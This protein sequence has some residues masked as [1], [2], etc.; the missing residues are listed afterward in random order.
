VRRPALPSGLTERAELLG[1]ER[2]S[3]GPKGLENLAQGLPGGRAKVMGPEGAPA[4]R[5]GC[6]G[7]SSAGA[8]SGPHAINPKT[9]GKPWAKLSWPFGPKTQSGSDRTGHVAPLGQALR[10]AYCP[11]PLAFRIFRDDILNSV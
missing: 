9:Q 1:V 2:G 6:V 7:A 11:L 3:R 8:L 4:F 10:A 5:E